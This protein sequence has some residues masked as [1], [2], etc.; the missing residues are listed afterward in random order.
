MAAGT[1][2]PL[3]KLHTQGKAD[4]V[5]DGVDCVY[6]SMPKVFPSCDS[7][8]RVLYRYRKENMPGPV[9]TTDDI[10]LIGEYA[11]CQDGHSRFLLLDTNDED[12]II[13]YGCDTCLHIMSKSPE[14]AIDGTFKSCPSV[15]YQLFT[16]HAWFFGQ[17]FACVY[18]HFKNVC[19]RIACS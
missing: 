6:L 13:C 14:W 9:Q 8:S 7:L 15:Y 19:A 12:R 5:A 3:P 10:V 2:I 18:V 16:I 11:V 1:Q 17:M 4:L